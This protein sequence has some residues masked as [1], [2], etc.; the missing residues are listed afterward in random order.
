MPRR[1]AEVAHQGL[2]GPVATMRPRRDA[3]ENT[4]PV[5]LLISRQISQ[6]LRA[7]AGRRGDQRPDGQVGRE[8]TYVI[9]RFQRAG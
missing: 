9:L 7:L 6:I 8:D 3:A 4:T 1:T 5:R 2:V